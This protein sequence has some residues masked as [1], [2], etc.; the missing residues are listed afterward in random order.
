MWRVRRRSVCG[1]VAAMFIVG[2]ALSM[3]GHNIPRWLYLSIPYIGLGMFLRQTSG[4]WDK[5]RTT[6]IMC[7]GVITLI[8]M[9]VEWMIYYRHCIAMETSI[10]TP[11]FMYMLMLMAFRARSKNIVVIITGKLGKTTTLPIYI[12]HRTIYALLLAVTPPYIKDFYKP[13]AL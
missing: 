4:K 10:L 12:Y 9:F 3:L 2:L 11:L 13:M 7:M 1:V 5:V 8:G 6:H